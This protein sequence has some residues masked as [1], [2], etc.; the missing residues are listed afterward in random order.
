MVKNAWDYQ[1]SSVHAH[2]SG[3]DNDRIILPNRLLSMTGDWRSYL[4]DAQIGTND[5]LAQHERTGRPLGS[6]SF[7]E[8]AERLLERKLKKKKPGPKPVE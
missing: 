8:K 1:W 6:D 3:K 5:S 2:L 4:Q 7:I